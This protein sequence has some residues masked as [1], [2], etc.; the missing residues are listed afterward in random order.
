MAELTHAPE[1]TAANRRPIPTR[2]PRATRRDWSTRGALFFWIAASGLVWI[3][4]AASAIW[5]S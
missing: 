4:L 2:A 5:F 3:A 1:N